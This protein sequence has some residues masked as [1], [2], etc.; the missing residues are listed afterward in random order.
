MDLVLS[1]TYQK[2]GEWAWQPGDISGIGCTRILSLM[3]TM[4]EAEECFFKPQFLYLFN[5]EVTLL[6]P[7]V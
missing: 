7:D 3:S 5:E 6:G 1:I 2:G 4:A